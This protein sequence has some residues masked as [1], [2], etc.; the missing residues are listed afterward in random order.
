VFNAEEDMI[1]RF[2]LDTILDLPAI[3]EQADKKGREAGIWN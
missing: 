1:S 2:R 3:L